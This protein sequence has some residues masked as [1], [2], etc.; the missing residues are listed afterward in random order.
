MGGIAR[1]MPILW[2]PRDS[3][4]LWSF[5]FLKAVSLK[6]FLRMGIPGIL[7]KRRIKL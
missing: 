5:I 1:K 3:I 7:E 4:F 6:G 2:L